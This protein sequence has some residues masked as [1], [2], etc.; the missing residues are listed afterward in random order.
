[1]TPGHYAEPY[2][3]LITGATDGI[4][5]AL[6]QHYARLPV[7]LVLVGKRPRSTLQPD[8]YTATRYCQVDLRASDCAASIARFLAQQAITRLD[9][10]IHNAGIGWYGKLADQPPQSI[11]DLLAVNLHA[12]MQITHALLPLVQRVQG[13][14]VFVSSIAADLPGPDYPV[15]CASKAALD[16]FARSLRIELGNTARVLVVH[17]GPTRTGIHAKSGIPTS[18]RRLRA[19]PAA[20][21]VARRI[22]AA[23]AQP[24]RRELTPGAPF[25]LL[26]QMGRH[27]RLADA[28]LYGSRSRGAPRPTATVPPPLCIITG[29]AEGIGQALLAQY[30][31]AGYPVLGV[32][33]NPTTT[34]A[35]RAAWAQQ[36]VQV[37]FIMADLAQHTDLERIVSMVQWNKAADQPVVLIH[38]AGINAVG[39]FVQSDPAAQQQ[40]IQINLRAPLVL[41][42]LLLQRGLLPPGSSIVGIAS[43]SHFVSYPGAAGYAASK[44]G[45]AAYAR[46]A[47][48]ALAAHGIHVLTVFPGPTRTAHARRY[49]PDNRHEGRRMP[50]ERLAAHIFRAQQRGQAVLLP[51]MST[52]LLAWLG[53]LAPTLAE[54]GMQR[55]ILERLTVSTGTRSEHKELV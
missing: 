53:R 5:R 21:W 3:V 17:P 41:T 37:P 43:L 23:I 44:D 34:A 1:M 12:P 11:D 8:L 28:L 25:A 47:R 26:R 4:G 39:R 19:Y 45:L 46:S 33:I 49:S 27:T 22:V 18:P 55:A 30:V 35:T 16:G 7:R 2:T 54:W 13:T 14:L 32:D 36:G 24:H 6:A 9:L 50:P 10:L 48:L 31:Q 20:A 51:G 52:R 29:A 15:Y 38:N 42:S 40:V